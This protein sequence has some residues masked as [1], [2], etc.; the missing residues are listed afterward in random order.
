MTIAT[1]QKSS[2]EI[3]SRAC[4]MLAEA[5]TIQKAHDLQNLALTAAD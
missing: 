1:Q 5:N 3:F 4:E 2:M